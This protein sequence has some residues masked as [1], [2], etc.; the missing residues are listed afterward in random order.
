[1]GQPVRPMLVYHDTVIL[2]AAPHLATSVYKVDQS[3]KVVKCLYPR[4][5][6][7]RGLTSMFGPSRPLVSDIFWLREKGV[8]Q[9]TEFRLWSIEVSWLDLGQHVHITAKVER[10]YVWSESISQTESSFHS[11]HQ[12]KSFG[13]SWLYSYCNNILPTVGVEIGWARWERSA[14][15]LAGISRHLSHPREQDGHGMDMGIG[16]RQEGYRLYESTRIEKGRRKPGTQSENALSLPTFSWNGI[17]L[18]ARGASWLDACLL[19]LHKE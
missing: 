15:S 6:R 8:S 19:V 18:R 1:M 2:I 7:A 11:H 16:H 12:A 14:T 13:L 5:R 3:Y 10:K 9:L 17:Q 4:N